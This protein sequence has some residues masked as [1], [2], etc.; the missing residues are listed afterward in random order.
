M[1]P[2]PRTQAVDTGG[3]V[4]G[5]VAAAEGSA[6]LSPGG[7][8]EPRGFAR[9]RHPDVP[10]FQG[11]VPSRDHRC[12]W[13]GGQ[14]HGR[15][16]WGSTEGLPPPPPPRP[17]NMGSPQ[18]ETQCL[19]TP[20]YS[21][22]LFLLVCSYICLSFFTSIEPPLSTLRESSGKQGP[23]VTWSQAVVWKLCLCRVARPGDGAHAPPTPRPLETFLSE[24]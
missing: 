10:A 19:V 4:T 14:V 13:K 18:T 5:T 21:S 9:N 20:S 1:R 15:E 12:P 2:S 3:T 16:V 6:P 11:R 8:C 23:E 22:E 24:V 17:S 7:T